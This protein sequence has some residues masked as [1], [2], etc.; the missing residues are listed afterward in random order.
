MSERERESERAGSSSQ[1]AD[2]APQGAAQSNCRRGVC[3]FAC[4]YRER[5]V[6]LIKGSRD[7]FE[8]LY[9]SRDVYTGV[10]LH[11]DEITGRK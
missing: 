2:C 4:V 3:V 5:P 8:V 11:L 1:V 10:L 9:E 7:Y 6:R